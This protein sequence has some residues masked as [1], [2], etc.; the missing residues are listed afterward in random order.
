MNHATVLLIAVGVV[1]DRRRTLLFMRL[2]LYDRVRTW[3]R[4]LAH[5]VEGLAPSGTAIQLDAHG[6]SVGT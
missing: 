5:R 6:V 1:V 3:N 2:L 4:K